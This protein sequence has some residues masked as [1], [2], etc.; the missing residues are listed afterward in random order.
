MKGHEAV[1]LSLLIAS[2]HLCLCGTNASTMTTTPPTRDR[3]VGG[4]EAELNEFPWMALGR[5]LTHQKISWKWLWKFLLRRRHVFIIYFFR[6]LKFSISILWQAVHD[7]FFNHCCDVLV[8]F[9]KCIELHHS[10]S[11]TVCTCVA[12]PLCHTTTSSRQPTVSPPAPHAQTLYPKGPYTCDVCKVYGFYELPLSA[13]ILE[14]AHNLVSF[15]C[16]L[17]TPFHHV[18]GHHMFL[19]PKT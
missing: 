5:N 14:N 15:V 11:T 19:L 13:L 18:H 9:V 2:I 7:Y 1:R 4:I 3:I 6:F 16:F 12:G 8:M 17:A 10:S